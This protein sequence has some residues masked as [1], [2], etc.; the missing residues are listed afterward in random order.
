[1]F[2]S[3][4][5]ACGFTLLV[6]TLFTGLQIYCHN[7]NINVKNDKSHN[8]TVS[9]WAVGTSLMQTTNPDKNPDQ[10]FLILKS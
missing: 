5:G 7:Y 6:S 2:F 1:M 4:L 3:G 8:L 9:K 10:V